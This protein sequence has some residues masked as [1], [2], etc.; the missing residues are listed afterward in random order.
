MP[1]VRVLIVCLLL[2]GA[3]WAG[4]H[5]VIVPAETIRLFNGKDL[6]PFYTWLVDYKYEDPDRVF[7]IVD[8]IDGAPAIRISGHRWGTLTTRSRYANYRLVVEFRW[9]LLSWGDRRNKAKDSGILLHA[10][11]EDGNYRADFNGPWM[12]S[13]EFQIIEGG[14]GDFILVGGYEKDG[15]RGVPALTVT[16]GKDR[17]GENVY[18]PQGAAFPFQGGRINWYGRDPDWEDRLG[19][20]GKEDLESPDGRWT[21]AEIICDGDTITHIVNGKVVNRGTRSSLGEGRI[22]FQSEG[23]E[24]FFRRIDLEPLRR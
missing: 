23:A 14:V 10:E 8:Q 4:Q 19:F 24:I 3:V 9:G 22:Q 5:E 20:R 1:A 13:I 15:R 18:H 7:S 17:D 2:T 6:S 21:R 16:S 12:R 11:G